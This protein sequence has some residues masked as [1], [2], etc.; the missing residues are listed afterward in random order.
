[1][2]GIATLITV[3]ILFFAQGSSEAIT[4]GPYSLILI[5]PYLLLIA[6]ALTGLNVFIVIT[7][8]LVFAFFLGYWQQGYSLIDFSGDITTGFSSMHEIMLLSLMVGGLSGL[9]GKGSK[10]L[11]AFLSSLISKSGGKV[12]AQLMIAKIVSL[13]D[14]LLAN[15]T[16]AIIFSGEI[17]R[18]IA[19]RHGIPKHYSAAWLDVFACVF[20]G[21]LPYGAQ[22]LLASSIAGIS[23]L[24]IVPHVYY[25]FALGGVSILFILFNKKI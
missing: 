14:I 21:L 17:A 18:D 13:F 12:M 24:S 11:A 22:I 9:A 1:V 19:K 8:A 4:A 2:G 6:L 23:P 20:Q 10:H 15:N 5:T 3:A 25:C 7:L 16:I